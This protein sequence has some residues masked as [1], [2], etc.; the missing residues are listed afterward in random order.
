MKGNLS[1]YYILSYLNVTD[2]GGLFFPFP[3]GKGKVGH[4]TP[5][6]G[7]A[8]PWNP[9]FPGLANSLLLVPA[10]FSD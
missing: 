9:A 6:Q 3:G 4:P 7:A 5:R 2:T 10:F 1:L 8:A